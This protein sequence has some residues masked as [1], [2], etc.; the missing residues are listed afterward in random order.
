VVEIGP[1]PDESDMP[2]GPA[3]LARAFAIRAIP[4]R[5]RQAVADLLQNLAQLRDEMAASAQQ[6]GK[7]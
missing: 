6:I 2:I 4:A 7:D 5:N 1:L 3:P